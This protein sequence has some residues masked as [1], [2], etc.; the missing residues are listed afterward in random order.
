MP[1]KLGLIASIS[2][3]GEFANIHDNGSAIDPIAFGIANLFSDGTGADQANQFFYDTRTVAPSA[4]EDLDVN[5]TAL[6]NVFG[7]AVALTKLRGLLVRAAPAN[8]NN[9]VIGNAASNGLASMFG[10]AT[11]T[12]I[13]PPGATLLLINPG[14]AG[15]AVTAGTGDL[16]RVANAAAGSPVDYTIAL[17]G[18]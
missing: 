1:T 15:Y 3:K 2:L 18:S 13:L 12:L 10:A 4:S 11:H 9:V 5:G 14:N 8:T 16:L 6:T 7:G 17:W